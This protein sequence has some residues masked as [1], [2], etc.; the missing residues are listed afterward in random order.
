M[1]EVPWL[2]GYELSRASFGKEWLRENRVSF[3]GRGYVWVGLREVT[4]IVKMG[5]PKGVSVEW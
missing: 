1:D 5:L 3:E 2:R 4:L